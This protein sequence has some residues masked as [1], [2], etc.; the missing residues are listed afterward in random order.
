MTNHAPII[1][2]ALLEKKERV[3]ARL[4]AAQEELDQIDGAIL[5]IEGGAVEGASE[6]AV[7]PSGGHNVSPPSTPDVLANGVGDGAVRASLNLDSRKRLLLRFLRDSRGAAQVSPLTESVRRAGYPTTTKRQ[8][9]YALKKLVEDGAVSFEARPD[10]NDNFYRLSNVAV[11]DLD[12]P[13]VN[14]DLEF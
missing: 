3:Q 4:A 11:S 8:V 2:Q 6:E 1:K 13:F 14:D 7:R 10:S 5:S 12:L 9:R